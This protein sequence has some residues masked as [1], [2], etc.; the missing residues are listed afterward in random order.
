MPCK[1]SGS[2][3]LA[4]KVLKWKSDLQMVGGVGV[5]GVPFAGRPRF[6]QG[7]LSLNRRR[8][9]I[10]ILNRVDVFLFSQIT[11]GGVL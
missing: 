9:I 4:G 1:C 11:V 3:A 7:I 2:T 10:E 5:G 6:R 8:R